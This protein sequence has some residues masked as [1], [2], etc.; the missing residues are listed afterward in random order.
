[1]YTIHCNIISNDANI[2]HIFYKNN[3][4]QCTDYSVINYN[5]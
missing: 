1:M 3:C 2:L 5:T 4:E